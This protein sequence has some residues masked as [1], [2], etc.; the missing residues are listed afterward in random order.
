MDILKLKDWFIDL[1][2]PKE[3]VSCGQ[4]GDYLCQQCFAKIDLNQKDCCALCHKEF[5]LSQICPD[6][7]KE[8]QLLNIWVAADYNN[9]ILQALIHNLKYKYVEEISRILASLIINY[10]KEKEVFRYL[11]INSQNT[12]FV[13]VPLHK[14]RYLER[15]F[16]Q[17]DLLANHLRDFY[18]I[19]K[20]VLLKRK[21]NTVSQVNLTRQERKINLANAFTFTKT[22]QA[23]RNKKIIL[24]DDV[25]TTGSTLKECADV[26]AKNGFKEIY[27]LVIAQ[28]ED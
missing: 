20:K 16:N 5:F 28:R 7:Q 10:L 24:I 12:W 3:C 27:G 2:F 21:L 1:V 25:I 6:C 11:N 22:E 18:K 19:E 26:L 14:K 4:E 9:E 23:D 15:G 13:A 17:S 8:S